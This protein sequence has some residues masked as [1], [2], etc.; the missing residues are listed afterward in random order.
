[1]ELSLRLKVKYL[2]VPL[3]IYIS[4]TRP[5]LCPVRYFDFKEKVQDHLA[6]YSALRS[7]I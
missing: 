2:Q 3:I 7:E 6:I 1:M 5:C 4:E